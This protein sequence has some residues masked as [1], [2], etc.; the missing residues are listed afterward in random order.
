MTPALEFQRITKSFFGVPVLKE[1]SFAV[2]SGHTLGIVGENGAGK[3]TLMNILGGNLQPDGGAMRRDGQPFAPANPRDAQRAGIAFVHQELNLFGNLSIAENIFLGGFP[4]RVRWLPWIDR[5][6]LRQ[7]TRQLLAEVN[8]PHEPDT[9][10]E[11]LSAGERQLVEIAKA[12]AGEA[13]LIILD[14]PTTSL[15]APSR[16]RGCS[17]SWPGCASAAFPCCTSRTASATC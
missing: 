2:P 10:L 14:E 11:R 9:P 4:R 16:P 3:S 1:V 8:L 5:R 15:T 7:R 17:P 13:R 12:L 6:Q